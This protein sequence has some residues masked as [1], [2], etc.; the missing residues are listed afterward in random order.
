MSHSELNRVSDSS[1]FIYCGPEGQSD[2]EVGDGPRHE[3]SVK[4]LGFILYL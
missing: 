1:C 4:S 3:E 2:H